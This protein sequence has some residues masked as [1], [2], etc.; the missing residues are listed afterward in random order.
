MNLLK[1]S[2]ISA[3]SNAFKLLMLFISN[4]FIAIYIG[5]SGI[6]LIGQFQNFINISLIFAGGGTNTGLIKYLSEYDDENKR[7]SF[8]STSYF[9]TLLSTFII[10]V[11][12]ITFNKYLAI[13][14]L[15]DLSYSYIF[16]IFAFCLILFSINSMLLSILNGTK[17]IKKL[18]LINNITNL[19][20]F[21]FTLTFV[22]LYKVNGALIALVS[23]QSAA[24]I[25]TILLVYKSDWFKIKNFTQKFDKD[26]LVKLF[27]FSLMTLISVFFINLSQIIIRNYLNFKFSIDIAGYWQ[28]MIKLSDLYLG[29]ITMTLSVY[30]LPRLSEIKENSLLKKEIFYGYKIIVPLILGMNIT[31]YLFRFLI[32]RLAFTEKFLPMTDL[33]A[34]QM[35]GDFFKIASWLLSYLMLAKAMT[36]VFIFTEI[37]F[38]IIYLL[39]S[40]I[41]I[42]SFGLIGTS[43][44]YA[45]S[46]FIYLL[47]I[48]WIFKSIVFLKPVKI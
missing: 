20:S 27:K 26:N 45:L 16:I 4:K 35:I 2:L 33:F 36:R 7:N 12:I 22:T 15:K 32:V 43:Y 3:I 14:L 41:F 34:F 25:F 37:F 28:S 8:I 29:F 38:V 30:Y 21:L 48:L 9:I 10:S 19:F 39:L 40:F 46:Y 1:V 24:F 42:N 44:A 11:L 5:P 17:E 13:T 18:M 23:A 47:L 31:I 6:A